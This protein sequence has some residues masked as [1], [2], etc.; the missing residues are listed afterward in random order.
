MPQT[1]AEE[2]E[3]HTD[4]VAEIERAVDYLVKSGK[5]FAPGPRR[6]ALPPL[7]GG[8]PYG[9][10][11]TVSLETMAFRT[12]EAYYR[13]SC[14]SGNV[15]TTF[16]RVRSFTLTLSLHPTKLL[17][18]AALSGSSKRSRPGPACKTENGRPAGA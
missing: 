13:C 1:N 15:P 14:A 17:R 16:D 9:D 18:L 8:R 7:A 4:A 10:H 3:K 12:S 5:L 6:D 2:V 11:G